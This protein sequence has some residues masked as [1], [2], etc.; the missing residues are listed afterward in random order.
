[1]QG[2]VHIVVGG[3]FGDEGKGKIV[4]YISYAEKPGAIVRTGATNAGHT[5][6]CC[7]NKWKL[8]AIPSGFINKDAKLYIARG[9]LIDKEVFMNEVKTLNLK[10][11]VWLD[12]MTGIITERHKNLEQKDEHFSKLGSTKTGVGAAMSERVLRKLKLA[13]DYPELKEFLTDTQEEILNILERGHNVLIEATQGYWLSL[14]HGTYPYVTSRDTTASGALSEVG[15]GPKYVKRVTVV[16]K[17]YVT[18][19]GTGPLPGEISFEEA[20][21]RGLLEFGTVTG[22]PRRVAPFNIDLA[23]R[24]VLAN[25]ATDVAITKLDVLFPEIRC[26]KDW[27]ELPVRVKSWIEEVEEALKAPVSLIGTGEDLNCTVSKRS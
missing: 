27:N 8:R 21:E 14:Y 9:A 11:R 2:G 1:M 26:K 18:R 10:G 6:V 12:Y 4:S 5:V 16:F 13:K 17:A 20:K 7:G 15:L 23:K 25:S 22:R 19:V 3:F 24:A